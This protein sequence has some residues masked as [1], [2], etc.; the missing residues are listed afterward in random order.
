MAEA[1]A[2][3][4]NTGNVDIYSAGSRPSGK[5]NTKAI[6]SMNELGYD[7]TKHTS[8]SL[9][10]IPNIEYEYVITMG[11]GDE[12]PFVRA[13]NREDWGIT[14]PKNL[15]MDE[16]NKARGQIEVKVKDLLARL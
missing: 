2:R 4:H 14:D 11:C 9:N 3:I 5:V 12:C 10:E 8:K 13:K 7:L 1:F 16:F 6:E 15:P